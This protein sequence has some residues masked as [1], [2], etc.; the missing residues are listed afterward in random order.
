MI[1]NYQKFYEELS[2]APLYHAIKFERAKLALD[3]NKLDCYSF[4]RIWPEGKRLKDDH[5]DYYKSQYL[6]GISLTRDF[7][8]AKSWNDIVFEFDQ[9]K[10]K[11]K[12]KI[13]PY[14]WGYSIGKGYKQGSNSKR[15][16]EEFL[17]TGITQE[18]NI[19][20]PVGS[21]EPLDRY[22]TGFWI[23]DFLTT[24]SGYD[25]IEELMNQ[26]LFSGF[27]RERKSFLHKNNI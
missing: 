22:L 4:Q 8:Y 11:N 14:N 13:T 3:K 17:I 10:L 18:L 16:R 21:I 26:P 23:D 15:E 25:D 6:R 9:D 12:F 1:L 27:Y 7:N 20:E 24:L 2:R 19:N 5:P